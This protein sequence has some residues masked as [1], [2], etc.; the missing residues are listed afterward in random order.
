MGAVSSTLPLFFIIKVYH[1][2]DKYE[3]TPAGPFSACFICHNNFNS[4][5]P[6][7]K[8]G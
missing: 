2:D 8:R 3:Q 6:G 5:V 1:G 4:A 7:I